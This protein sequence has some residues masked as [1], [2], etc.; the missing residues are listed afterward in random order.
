VLIDRH[1]EPVHG[2]IV[3]VVPEGEEEYMI[4]RLQIRE[5]GIWLAS[6]HPDYPAFEV[7]GTAYDIF[8]VVT[9]VIKGL[10]FT[11]RDAWGAGG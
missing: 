11:P 5:N 2:S 4:K 9:Y 8:G 6:E 7:T 10:S 1:I 3:I